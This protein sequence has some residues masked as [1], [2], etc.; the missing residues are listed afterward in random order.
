MEKGTEF[1]GIVENITPPERFGD[2]SEIEI[3]NIK[4]KDTKGNIIELDGQVRKEGT[5]R[6]KWVKPLYYIGINGGVFGAPLMAFYFVKGGKAELKT[7]D[8][9]FFYYE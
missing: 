3:G 5:N 8:E 4:S 1:S 2:P 7:Q 9:F 6:A